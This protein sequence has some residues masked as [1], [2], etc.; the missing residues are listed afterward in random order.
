MMMTIKPTTM[1]V[2]GTLAFTGTGAF[3]SIGAQTLDGSMI[4]GVR[5]EMN[6]SILDSF[7]AIVDSNPDSAPEYVWTIDGQP[8][9]G[10]F[11]DFHDSTTRFFYSWAEWGGAYY[12]DPASTFIFTDIDDTMADFTGIQ[13]GDF[14]GEEVDWTQLDFGLIDGN[15]FYV[16]FT[17]ISDDSMLIRTGDFFDLELTFAPAPA[18]VALF[19]GAGFAGRRRRT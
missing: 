6:G 11:I 16:D 15:Q 12:P 9:D 17:G 8:F 14:F 1:V 18:S 5:A 3:A 2:M 13:L 4:E 7:S 10:Y 19:L